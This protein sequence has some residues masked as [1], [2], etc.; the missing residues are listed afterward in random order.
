MNMY[1]ARCRILGA[2]YRRVNAIRI[3]KVCPLHILHHEK[4][5]TRARGSKV[6]VNTLQEDLHPQQIFKA[7][8]G[9]C[10]DYF[11]VEAVGV[12]TDSLSKA[13]AEPLGF[14]S[15][16]G[17]VVNHMKSGKRASIQDEPA[18]FVPYSILSLLL[19]V[20]DGSLE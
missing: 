17:H 13:L 4:R 6:R 18:T 12:S 14:V 3:F 20:E 2:Q 7:I 1:E 16:C 5:G 8:S 11:E 9:V 19:A 10:L 15:P